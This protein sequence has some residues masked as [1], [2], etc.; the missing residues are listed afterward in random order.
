[1][2][3]IIPEV[4]AG[5]RAIV[6]AQFQHAAAHAFHIGHVTLL[7]AGEG[8]GDFR[9]GTGVEVLKPLLEGAAAA[10]FRVLP[11]FDRDSR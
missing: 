7:Q 10:R 11:H 6:D 2:S 1:M 3:S 4:D 9:G 5:A 8:N